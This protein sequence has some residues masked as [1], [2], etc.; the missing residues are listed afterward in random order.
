MWST[1]T[2]NTWI[3]FFVFHS[4]KDSLLFEVKEKT[5][6]SRLKCLKKKREEKKLPKDFGPTFVLSL[7]RVSWTAAEN[8]RSMV[9]TDLYET[10]AQG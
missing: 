9:L 8:M 4:P 7:K 10:A 2:Q 1:A 6:L 5:K 3:K